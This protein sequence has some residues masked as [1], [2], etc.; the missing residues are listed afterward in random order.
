M[1]VKGIIADLEF[2]SS[3]AVALQGK[4]Q[5]QAPVKVGDIAFNVSWTGSGKT[6]L[7]L[8]SP[9]ESYLAGEL[10]KYSSIGFSGSSTRFQPIEKLTS[11]IAVRDSP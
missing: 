2:T 7:H 8:E 11:K 9:A 4:Y 5:D 3:D 1:K 6:V 10:S